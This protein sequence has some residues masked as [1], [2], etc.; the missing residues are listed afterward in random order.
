MPLDFH[1]ELT[2]LDMVSSALEWLEGLDLPDQTRQDSEQ[3]TRP[4]STLNHRFNIMAYKNTSADFDVT[5]AVSC[6]CS[7][8]MTKGQ[9]FCEPKFSPSGS[10]FQQKGQSHSEPD[11]TPTG[12]QFY[13][14][15]QSRG[16]TNVF[17]FGSNFQPKE[18]SHR[19]PE[20]VPTGTHFRPAEQSRPESNDFHHGSLQPQG[21]PAGGQLEQTEPLRR[22]ELRVFHHGSQFPWQEMTHR[23][24]E[25]VPTG[26]QYSYSTPHVQPE[27]KSCPDK[28]RKEGR[29]PPV[30]DECKD[31][32]YWRK[33]SRNNMSAQK[34]RAAKRLRDIYIAN[35]ID[36]LEKENAMLKVMLANFMMQRQQQLQSAFHW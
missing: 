12:I 1:T 29:S 2:R 18:K 28:Q 6:P 25:V 10:Q 13:P 9:G 14:P 35:K 5:A 21:V 7:S 36:Q 16:E 33:R 32:G 3:V 34:S 27:V 23:G 8:G 31:A 26:S 30:P 20:V 4:N 24:R 19:G 17:L 22:C 15:K 11:V